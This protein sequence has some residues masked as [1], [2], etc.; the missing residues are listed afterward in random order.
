MQS[1]RAAECNVLLVTSAFPEEGK[2]TTSIN[3]AAAFA[4]Q[5]LRVLLVEADLRR[6]KLSSQLNLTST[7]GLSSLISGGTSS[8]LPLKMPGV[9]NLSI[10]PAGPRSGYPAELLGSQNAKAL[11]TQWRS[12]Y[13]YI[14]IDSPPVLSVTDAAVLAPFCDGVIMVL[15]SGITTKKSLTR[16]MELF[17]RTQTRIVGTVLNAFDVNSEDYRHYFGYKSTEKIG[18]GYYVSENN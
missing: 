1:M 9:S 6:P 4:Q 14:F 8:G 11:I 18:K 10:I 2:T 5:G 17:R 7:N 3:C 13:D 16:A 15:R 12:E